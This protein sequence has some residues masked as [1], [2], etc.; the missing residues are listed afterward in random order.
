M[1][2][3]P[4]AQVHAHLAAQT[5][6][7]FVKT[8]TPLDGLPFN[9]RVTYVAV[10][11]DPRDVVL[12]LRHHGANLRREVIAAL[13]GQAPPGSPPPSEP[14]EAP[15]AH[16][17]VRRWIRNDD[18]PQ[19]NLDS[20]RGVVG[21]TEQAWSR[22]HLPGVVLLHYGDLCRDLEG[23]MRRMAAHLGITVPEPTWPLLVEAAGFDQMR[24]NAADRVPDE[25]LGIMRN[26]GSFF[27]AGTTGGWRRVLTDDDLAAYDA[28]VGALAA[29]E[30]AH[31]LHHGWGG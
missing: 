7:R 3:R 12:S 6:R 10:G 27:R 8:H 20:L 9:D 29:P 4:V 22:R 16:E 30:L 5:H 26:P 2:V 11:R 25:R 17:F 23:Q 18:E 24:N 14:G 15:D 28:R 19:A 31:W 13:V 1:R 21:Q